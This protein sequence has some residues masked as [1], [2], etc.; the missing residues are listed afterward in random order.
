MFI[1]VWVCDVMQLWV[2]FNTEC[3]YVMLSHTLYEFCA[4]T[5]DGKDRSCYNYQFYTEE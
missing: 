3:M 2:R 1:F 5:Y 4:S